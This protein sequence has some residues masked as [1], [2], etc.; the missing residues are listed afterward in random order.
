MSWTS[1]KVGSL[2]LQKPRVAV[3]EKQM[4]KPK[5]LVRPITPIT[6]SYNSHAALWIVK[7]A[8]DQRKYYAMDPTSTANDVALQSYQ[9]AISLSNTGIIMMEHQCFA[10]AAATL[11]DALELMREAAGPSNIYPMAGAARWHHLLREA[12]GR[13]A[14]VLSEGTP[15]SEQEDHSR[16]TISLLVLS[17][18]LTS[19]FVQAALKAP[20]PLSNNAVAIRIDDDKKEY[21]DD[22][23]LRFQLDSATILFNYA[24]ATRCLGITTTSRR[25]DLAVIAR[26][27]HKCYHKSYG[28]LSIIQSSKE[29]STGTNDLQAIRIHL[30]AM[31]AVQNLASSALDL[32][33]PELKVAEYY[34]L[35]G[36]LQAMYNCLERYIPSLWNVARRAAPAA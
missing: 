17:D 11:R 14:S 19:D 23:V 9:A 20:S 36:G 1:Q 25:Y 12:S 7:T 35:L 30:L 13:L 4:I 22:S 15:T 28:I 21:D 29:Y 32:H 34:H 2:A 26:A 18:D 31:L 33:M 3:T 8:M 10:E 27:A 24:T 16:S 5:V 6:K